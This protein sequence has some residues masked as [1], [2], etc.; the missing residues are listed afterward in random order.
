MPN[1]P[2]LFRVM[3]ITSN[4]AMLEQIRT[5]LNDQP[6]YLLIDRQAGDDELMEALENARPNCVLLDF[7]GPPANPLGMIDSLSL[8]FPDMTVVV[9]L[10]A[11]KLAEANRLILAGARAFI[12]QPFSDKELLDTLGRTREL[13]QR[14]QRSKTVAVTE[15]PPMATRGTFV[16]FSSKGGVG[17]ST[18]AIN[19]AI[20]LKELLGQEVLL[21][22]AK[23]L[24]GDV[25]IMLNLKTR[26]SISDLVPHIGSLDEGLISAVVSEHVSGV[27][28]L[29]API[30]PTSAQG[31][32]PEELHRILTSVQ[33]IYPNVV[34]DAGNFLNENAVTI[35]DSS[36]RVILVMGPDIA[37]LRDASRFFDLCRTTLS[38]SKEKSWWSSINMIG[39]RG[40]VWMTSSGPCKSAHLPHC[41]GIRGCPCGP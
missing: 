12:S 14:S 31:I 41:R 17:C 4:A 34:I 18:I 38:I 30:N 15:E 40:S 28:V 16:V 39:R 22:D 5:A 11:N 1:P 8:Q 19:L 9:L 35:M 37:S 10:P 26:N 6:D 27:K 25:D 21:M 24:F 29:P 23:L 36:H 3:P 13:H 20:A 32:H 33:N 2:E 7:L